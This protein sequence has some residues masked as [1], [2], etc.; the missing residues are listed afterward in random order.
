MLQLGVTLLYHAADLLWMSK[1]RGA[2][3]ALG[4]PVRAVR[5]VEM[6]EARLAD[7]P[8]K[9]LIVDLDAPEVALA[10][11]E[12]AAKGPPGAAGPV[13]IAAFGPHVEV[14]RFAQAR[15]AGAHDVMARGA[16]AARMESVLRGLVE[17]S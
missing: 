14:E 13:R 10:L 9:G 4:I 1:I 8:V 11:I 15:A 3:E 17:P 2:A 16:L 5:S 12:R 6:L 7:T